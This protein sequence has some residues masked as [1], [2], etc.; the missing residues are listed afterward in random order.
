M[1]VINLILNMLVG[2]C[3][4]VFCVALALLIYSEWVHTKLRNWLM[5]FYNKYKE[6]E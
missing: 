4:V 6:D 2:V 5:D 1:E 3:L